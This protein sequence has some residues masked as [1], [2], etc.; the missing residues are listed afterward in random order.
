MADGFRRHESKMP[1]L[2]ETDGVPLKDKEIWL[3]FFR[4]ESDS[5]WMAAETNGRGLYFGCVVLGG[6]FD[7]AEWAYFTL[8][9]M[10]IAPGLMV[11]CRKAV[12]RFEDVT[13]E[14][15]KGSP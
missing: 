2:G 15:W 12:K 7:D 1:R 9:E 3:H 5:H 13:V 10:G 6:D 4:L 14:V 11:L 8:A